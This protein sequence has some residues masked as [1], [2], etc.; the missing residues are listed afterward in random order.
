MPDLKMIC[1]TNDPVLAKIAD[2][3]G[4]AYVA[5]DLEIIGKLDRQGHLDTR[6][7]YHQLEDI[8][9]IRPMVQ[10]S[11]LLV[12]INPIHAN[13]QME[14]DTAVK[15]GADII[16]LPF[17]KTVSEVTQ[18]HAWVAGR[19]KTCLLVETAEAVMNIKAILDAGPVD[20]IHIG[21]ND[22]SLSLRQKFLFEPLLDPRFLDLCALLRQRQIPFGFGGIAQLNTGRLPA[23]LILA[24]HYRLGS[25]MVILARSFMTME[26]TGDYGQVRH[27]FA[28]A[29]EHIRD[30]EKQL[31]QK[32]EAFFLENRAIMTEKIREIVHES[33]E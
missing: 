11:S 16:M 32:P 5:I 21:L 9:K 6:I 27:D 7:S 18:F 14:I 30:Y 33:A 26:T 20:C 31:R 24:E 15:E 10:R 12:R 28:A 29:V 2:D 13:S 8:R 3:T 22:L 1:F 25:S 23:Q 4:I 19:V 17:F